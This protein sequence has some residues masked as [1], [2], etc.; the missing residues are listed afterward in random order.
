MY[1][2]Q[3]GVFPFLGQFGYCDNDNLFKINSKATA[4][5]FYYTADNLYYA[6]N[7]GTFGNTEP[8]HTEG[9]ELNGDVKLLRISPIARYEM[10]NK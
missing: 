6:L 9:V 10:R 1:C 8:T 4:G 7:A 2:T 3:E 5:Y